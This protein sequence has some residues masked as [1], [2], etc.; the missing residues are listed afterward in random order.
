[1]T[2]KRRW[3]FLRPSTAPIEREISK[4]VLRQIHS[5][6]EF[7]NQTGLGYIT[8]DRLTKTLSGGEAQRVAIAAQLAASLTGVLYIL[9]EPSAGLHPGDVDTLISQLKNLSSRGNTVVV[10]E[11][12]SSIIKESDYIVEIGPGAGE[13]GGRAVF[14]GT[15][16]E[17]FSAGRTITA[18]SLR[19]AGFLT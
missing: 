8:L 15:T 16:Q 19:Q 13:S 9:D 6:L 10:V 2:I 17:F 7:L 1:M 12:D 3:N 5:K 11:H 14:T 4:E 18:L